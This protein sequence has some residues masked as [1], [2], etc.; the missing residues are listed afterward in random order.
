MSRFCLVFVAL[1]SRCSRAV[2]ALFSHFCRVV[3]LLSLCYRFVV[4]LLSC[5]C[6]AQC[7]RALF[8]TLLHAVVALLLRRCRALSAKFSCLRLTA[9]VLLGVFSYSLFLP[10]LLCDAVD[11]DEYRQIFAINL[12]SILKFL[13]LICD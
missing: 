10:R 13:L 6:G 5:F 7:Y 4:V 11:W 9:F 3:V 12:V 1:L 2:L 8:F